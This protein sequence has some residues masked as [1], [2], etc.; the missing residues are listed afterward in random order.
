M[1]GREP[2][3]V[4]TQQF[5]EP[6]DRNCTQPSRRRSH[7]LPYLFLRASRRLVRN[8]VESAMSCRHCGDS[9]IV[10]VVASMHIDPQTDELRGEW[11]NTPYASPCHCDTGKVWTEIGLD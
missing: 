2:S 4:V 11:K 5:V 3:L 6:S 10:N 9:G 7:S 1:R 8:E